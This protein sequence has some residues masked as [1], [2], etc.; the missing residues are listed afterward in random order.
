MMPV[1]KT[2]V[3]ML[4]KLHSQYKIHAQFRIRI[5]RLQMELKRVNSRLGYLRKRA[6]SL[7]ITLPPKNNSGH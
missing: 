3:V 7:G 1:V 6:K 4:S 2:A 5:F